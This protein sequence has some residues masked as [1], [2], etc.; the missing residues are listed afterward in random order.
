MINGNVTEFVDHIYYGD[1]LIFI[2]IG[3]KF[4]FQGLPENGILVLYLDRREPPA[5]DYI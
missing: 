2:Y 5:E 4:F 3:P 1:E